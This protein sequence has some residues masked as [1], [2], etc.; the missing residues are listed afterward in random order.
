MSGLEDYEEGL[1]P[2]VLTQDGKDHQPVKPAR[3]TMIGRAVFA[4]AAF[5]VDEV[6]GLVTGLPFEPDGQ[7]V[8][9]S[10]KGMVAIAYDR[11]LP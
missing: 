4:T 5:P 2:A 10:A 8:L 3:F 9:D 11:K 7:T 1:W 6:N